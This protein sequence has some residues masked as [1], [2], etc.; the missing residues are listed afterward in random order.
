MAL[1]LEKGPRGMDVYDERGERRGYVQS[2]QDSF[3]ARSPMGWLI[4]E[5]GSRHDAVEAVVGAG[6]RALS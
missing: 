3:V 2:N 5:Y 6:W 4:G 1:R